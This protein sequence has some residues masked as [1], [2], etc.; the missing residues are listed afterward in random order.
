MIVV[1]KMLTFDV[2]TL[3]VLSVKLIDIAVY[4]QS[5]DTY[6]YSYISISIQLLTMLENLQITRPDCLLPPL[7][8]KLS[9]VK[10]S[11]TKFIQHVVS[12]HLFVEPSGSVN[13]DKPITSQL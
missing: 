11:V 7:C 13:L 2:W 8:F 12:L 5:E 6:M 10:P 3:D 9:F 4:F 1:E